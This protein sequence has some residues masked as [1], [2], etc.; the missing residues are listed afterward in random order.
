M[1]TLELHHGSP[2]MHQELQAHMM[3]Q[4]CESLGE[5]YA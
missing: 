2:E 5:D 1:K 3:Q 4:G